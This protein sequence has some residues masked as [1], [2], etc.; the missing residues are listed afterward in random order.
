MF[1]FK[2]ALAACFAVVL[3]SG[4]LACSSQTAKPG[5]DGAQANSSPS[6]SA[7]DTPASP[8]ATTPPPAGNEPAKPADMLPGG[9]NDISVKDPGVM[10]AANFACTAEQDALKAKGQ[11]QAITLVEITAAQSQVVAGVSCSLTLH[12]KVDG[13]DQTAEAVVWDRGGLKENDKLKLTSWKFADK[14]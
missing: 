7:A 2:S 5:G 3:V 6:L 12:V 11:P 1:Q 4:G 10:D 9:K 8:G 14:K 13:Q